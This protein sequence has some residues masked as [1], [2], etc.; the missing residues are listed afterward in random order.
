MMACVKYTHLPLTANQKKGY[1]LYTKANAQNLQRG[2]RFPACQQAGISQL[3]SKRIL[4]QNLQ[5]I[6]LLTL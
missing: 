6:G 4:T 5:L 1:E 2:N 3:V